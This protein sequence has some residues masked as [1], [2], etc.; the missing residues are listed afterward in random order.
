MIFVMRLN[1]FSH[2]VPS[3]FTFYDPSSDLVTGWDSGTGLTFAEIDDGI[4]Q[5]TTTGFLLN[6]SD[7]TATIGGQSEFFFPAI[8]EIPE[9][10]TL[11]VYTETERSCFYTFSLQ[12]NG[13]TRCSNTTTSGT[14]DPPGWWSCNW[15]NPS[16]QYSNMTIELSAVGKGAGANSNCWVSGA[17]LEVAYDAT[18]PTWRNRGQNLSI[19]GFNHSVLLFAQGRDETNLSYAVLSTNESGGWVNYTDGTYGSPMYIGSNITWNW[20]NFTWWNESILGDSYVGWRIWYNDTAGNWNGT[21]IQ[22][23]RVVDWGSYAPASP[24][25]GP[26]NDSFSSGETIQLCADGYE[27]AAIY[28]VAIYNASGDRVFTESTQ[29]GVVSGQLLP[30]TYATTTADGGGN[31]SS[32][33][34]NG[35]PPTT[36][37]RNAPGLIVEDLSACFGNCSFNVTGACEISLVLS[38]NLSGG[39][40]WTISSLPAFNE[41]ASGNN[42]TGI[43]AYNA[44]TTASGCTA[45]LW[46]KANDNLRTTD[47]LNSI[48]L[49][50]ETYRWN[51][52]NAT[53]PGNNFT[54]LTTNYALIK[55]GLSGTSEIYFKFFLNVSG[56]QAAGIYNNSVTIKA[57]KTA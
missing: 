32:Q 5:P 53:V 13:F 33:V 40:N 46:I 35:T 24:C 12:Q 30:S 49:D 44:T 1:F 51:Q 25:A 11:W 15:T 16:G 9:Y 2:A 36:Y 37:D 45:D 54:S 41:S 39:I 52:T 19:V 10:I 42:G 48:G 23:F 7:H 18:P 6:V 29:A 27:P 8:T 50:N 21:D 22:S 57:N 43:T 4:R 31:W 38:S 3:A 47:G 56:G 55:S 20:S 28:G 26:Q 17:Y 34:F 14:V